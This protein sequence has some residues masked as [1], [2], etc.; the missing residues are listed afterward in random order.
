M[1]TFNWRK[2]LSPT[3]SVQGFF[4]TNSWAYTII[5]IDV[6][7]FMVLVVL[8]YNNIQFCLNENCS[9]SIQ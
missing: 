6:P 9:R 4:Y 5:I 7:V 2:V 1:K 3:Q 8:L